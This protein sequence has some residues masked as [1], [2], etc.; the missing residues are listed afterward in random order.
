MIAP[1]NGRSLQTLIQSLHQATL[2]IAELADLSNVLQR[3]VDVAQETIGADYVALGVPNSDGSLD[4]FIYAGIDDR[5]ADHIT[6]HPQGLGLLGAIIRDKKV[7][8]IDAI[9]DDSRSIGF[10]E[11]HPPM[12]PLLGVPI[13]AGDEILGNL[14]LTN[15]INGRS[16]TD[17]DQELVELLA[18]HAAVAIQNAR[19]YGQVGRLAIVEE[20]TR[21]GMDLHDGVIQS[22]YAVGLTLESSRLVMQDDPADAQ[23]LVDHAINAL[24]STIRDIRNFI[25]DLRPH[26]FSGDLASSLGRLMREF[27][28]NTMVPVAHTF[29]PV[30]F[31]NLPSSVSR[32]LFLTTQEALANIARHAHASQVFISLGRKNERYIVLR[33]RDDGDGFDVQTKNYSIGH[34]LSNMRARAEDLDGSFEIESVPGE[35]TTIHLILPIRK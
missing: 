30:E 26:R 6:H 35:G 14:Y 33:I 1:E 2:A 28:A 22:I 23:I 24:N 11:G 34:G 18:A 29:D 12:V 4:A 10:P 15:K 7:I 16:F 27:Q 25:L 17:F 8:R 13:R 19:L 3:I 20:R 31:E 9:Q 21:I 5:E 32:S